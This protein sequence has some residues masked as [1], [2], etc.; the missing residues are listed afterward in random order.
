MAFSELLAVFLCA[1]TVFGLCIWYYIALK[2]SESELE[3]IVKRD[4]TYEVDVAYASDSNEEQ[5]K[6][7]NKQ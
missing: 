5:E 1:F 3:R 2:R 6:N 7:E 4:L